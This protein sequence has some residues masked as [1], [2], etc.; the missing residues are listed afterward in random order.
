MKKSTRFEWSHPLTE[1]PKDEV[2]KAIW[3][4]A[5]RLA[6]KVGKGD[7]Q[8]RFWQDELTSAGSIQVFRAWH[9]YWRLPRD[10]WVKVMTT[11]MI[12]AMFTAIRKEKVRREF[13][14]GVDANFDECTC[15]PKHPRATTGVLDQVSTSGDVLSLDSYTVLKLSGE[16]AAAETRADL[17]AI[18]ACAREILTPSEYEVLREE[19][20]FNGLDEA[21]KALRTNR[22][23]G[24]YR[25]LKSL[26]IKKIGRRVRG[27]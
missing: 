24:S 5:S 23:D 26:G 8:E 11:V 17:E 13:F 3:E 10:Q 21:T 20:R 25:S 2:W 16:M 6:K 4:W 22:P 7:F 12:F 19:M 9:R 27:C 1:D 15:R 18:Y 14:L